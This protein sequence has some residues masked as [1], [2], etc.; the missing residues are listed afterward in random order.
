MDWTNA[1]VLEFLH[2]YELEPVLWD[3]QNPNHKRKHHGFGA[4][5]RI[6]RNLT[7][8]CKIEDLKK[9][10]DSLMASYRFH[11]NKIKKMKT[12]PTGENVYTTNWFAFDCMNSFLG[13][14]YDLE[15]DKTNI[16]EFYQE[17]SIEDVDT[18]DTQT[19][20]DTEHVVPAKRRKVKEE[21][22]SYADEFQTNLEKQ[23]KN[24]KE[25]CET[26]GAL[27]AQKLFNLGEE[28][29]LILM[30]QIDNLVFE[31]AL[32]ARKKTFA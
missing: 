29:R 30:N 8:D 32:Q 28:D 23:E 25:L 27:L 21:S 11:C 19:S 7:W 16:D 5:E 15:Y 9:K 4:W 6:M 18:S 31:T 17:A 24:C 13:R 3:P 14:V 1:M 10:K 26:Y 22:K 2:N 20:K 12:D